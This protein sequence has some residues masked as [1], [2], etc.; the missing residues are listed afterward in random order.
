MDSD[1]IFMKKLLLMIVFT[2]T[3]FFLFSFSGTELRRIPDNSNIFSSH[4]PQMS[5]VS[6]NIIF[7]RSLSR[8]DIQAAVDAASPGDMIQLPPGIKTDFSGTV[9]ITKDNLHLRG[10]GA[11]KT[12]IKVL[13]INQNRPLF[14]FVG[15]S[16]CRLSNVKLEASNTKDAQEVLV[17]FENSTNFEVSYCEFT[18]SSFFCIGVFG[19]P[20]VGVIHN[21]YFHDGFRPGFGY[22]VYVNGTAAG[23]LDGDKGDASWSDPLSL[24]TTDGLYVEDCIMSNFRHY[25]ASADGARYIARYNTITANAYSG[26]DVFDTHGYGASAPGNRGVRK[27][28]IYENTVNFENGNWWFHIRDSGDGVIF[29]NTV[30]GLPAQSEFLY[31][32]HGCCNANNCGSYP[33]PDQVRNLYVWGNQVNGSAYN[34]ANE[35]IHCEDEAE[36]PYFRKNRDWFDYPMPGYSP[37]AYPHPLRQSAGP[38]IA[39]STDSLE[40]SAL[41]GGGAPASQMI[42]IANAGGGLLDWSVSDNAA[43]LSSSPTSGQEYGV[44]SVSVDPT[45]LTAG[46]H[47]ARISISSPNADNSPQRILV[48]FS[49]FSSAPKQLSIQT[50]TGSPASGTGGTTQPEPG[51]HSVSGGSQI[52]IQAQPYQNYRF[53]SWGGDA[54]ASQRYQSPMTLLMDADKYIT[55]N[56]CSR[57]GDINGDFAIT[58]G[59]AQIAFDIYLGRIPNPSF[60]QL[61]NADVNCDGTKNL[62]NV[63]PMDAQL[64]FSKFLGQNE[65]PTS[66]SAILRDDALLSASSIATST[67]NARL[68]TD[69]PLKRSDREL[70][71][72]VII[73]DPFAIQAFGFDLIFPSDHLQFVSIEETDFSGKFLTLGANLISS[74]VVRVGGYAAAPFPG[75]SPALIALV[76]LEETEI[77]APIQVEIVN[78]VDDLSDIISQKNCFGKGKRVPLDR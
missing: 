72:P 42:Q 22:G 19:H 48:T 61:E 30:T 63:T 29:N 39:L 40:Y 28:E 4:S 9:R 25:I 15:T 68:F 50:A 44:I 2:F 76:F 10:Q 66:C 5:A 8:N 60:C 57:C 1:S 6:S 65:L 74:G 70:I 67:K 27:C 14:L 73:N 3:P 13:G 71:I 17:T 58:P 32:N 59:D 69:S 11:S 38:S 49:Y 7:A 36:Y 34:A 46:T 12:Q 37:L 26:E 77:V 52:Q 21:N 18:K 54:N 51:L 41:V 20:V 64:I 47:T 55:A 78:V 24:G 35:T 31:L 75:T 16:G 23:E 56:F 33:L 43:W 45:N 53:S 62:P